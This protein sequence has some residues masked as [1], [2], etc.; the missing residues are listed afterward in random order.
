M[1]QSQKSQKNRRIARRII[2]GAK[3]AFVV[4]FLV[5]ISVSL[6]T[7]LVFVLGQTDGKPHEFLGRQMFMQPTDLM[8][9]SLPHYSLSV[10]EPFDNA[11]AAVG[12]VDGDIIIFSYKSGGSQ[13]IGAGRLI[14]FVTEGDEGYEGRDY[15]VIRTDEDKTDGKPF[16]DVSLFADD[17]AGSV[18]H[19]FLLPVLC[20]GIVK[21]L[22]LL[23]FTLILPALSLFILQLMGMGNLA[24]Q[25]PDEQEDLSLSQPEQNGDDGLESKE[26][27]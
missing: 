2:F 12:E 3:I 5:T 13:R 17:I 21:N 15:Y 14:G 8:Q 1:E 18:S 20:I 4:Y 26:V 23:I 7:F 27:E 16:Y 19:T 11:A 24:K 6:V 10:L 25:I 9:K 22:S